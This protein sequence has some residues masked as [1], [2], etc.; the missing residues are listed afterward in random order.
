MSRCG[1]A[2]AYSYTDINPIIT[3]MISFMEKLFKVAAVARASLHR[4][5]K[6]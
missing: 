5:K 1:L 4:L 2:I 6:S 3:I